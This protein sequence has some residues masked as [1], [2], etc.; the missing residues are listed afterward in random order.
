MLKIELTLS[1]TDSR[2][3]A[4]LLALTGIA[5]AKQSTEAPKTDKAKKPIEKPVIPAQEVTEDVPAIA[6]DASDKPVTLEQIREKIVEFTGKDKALYTPKVKALLGKYGQASA[7]NLL[8]TDYPAF[9]T[10]L[11]A[12]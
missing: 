9:Y 11:C 4:V 1:P 7:S 6:P 5:P 8:K 10:E 3:D 12:L 2:F